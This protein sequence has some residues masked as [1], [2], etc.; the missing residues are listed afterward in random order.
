[1]PRSARSECSRASATLS[2]MP[3]DDIHPTPQR[4]FFERGTGLNSSPH[5]A[6][7]SGNQKRLQGYRFA[8]PKYLR[9]AGFA[10]A[11]SKDRILSA[12]S[13]GR[14]LKRCRSRGNFLGELAEKLSLIFPG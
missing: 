7:L 2:R 8:R 10:A 14:G 9:S 4:R 3:P 13:G 12:L 1:M 6:R 11:D 5:R